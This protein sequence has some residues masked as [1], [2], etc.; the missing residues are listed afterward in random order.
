MKLSTSHR[1]PELCGVFSCRG[2]GAG[3]AVGPITP[4]WVQQRLWTEGI[5]V[6][7]GEFDQRTLEKLVG[8]ASTAAK[9]KTHAVRNVLTMPWFVPK[10]GEVVTR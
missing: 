8:Q 9:C 1:N 5:G 2:L 7:N 3:F 10:E 6:V 4:V